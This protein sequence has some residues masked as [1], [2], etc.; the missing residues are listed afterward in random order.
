MS[1]SSKQVFIE[2][3][4]QNIL[5]SPDCYIVFADHLTMDHVTVRSEADC[6]FYK[7]ARGG[8]EESKTMIY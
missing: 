7:S 8:D 2:Y 5:C 3:F 1:T 6:R 4:R